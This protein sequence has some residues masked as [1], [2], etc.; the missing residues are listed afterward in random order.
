MPTSEATGPAIV[1]E[2]TEPDPR[3]AEEAERNGSQSESYLP[4]PLGLSTD[5]RQGPFTGYGAKHYPDPRTAP[6]ANVREAVLDVITTDGPLPKE[7][8]YRLYRDG[9]PRIERTGKHLRQAIN[10]AIHSLERAGLVIS[11]DE[12]R[13]RDPGDVAVRLVSQPTV[14]RRPAGA[15]GLE[16]VP[17]SELAAA[18]HSLCPDAGSLSDNERV[19]LCRAVAREFGIRRITPAALQR[20]RLAERKD[21]QSSQENSAQLF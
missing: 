17:L 15:R 7:S 18:M 8:V 11:C 21:L 6:A 20:L 4:L 9:C 3:L 12:G 14:V 10:R 16:D 19:D 13:R 2:A 5:E 1:A